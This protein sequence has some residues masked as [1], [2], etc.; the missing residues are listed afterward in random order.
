MF[1]AQSIPELLQTARA[2]KPID[3]SKIPPVIGVAV[4][5]SVPPATAPQ[6][7]PLQTASPSP[8]PQPPVVALPINDKPVISGR[9][10]FF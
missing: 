1:D 6:H 10:L 3:E 8:P 2:G 4:T 9:K 5:S 7:A